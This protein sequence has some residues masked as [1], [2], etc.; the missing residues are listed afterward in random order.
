MVV[1]ILIQST[2]DVAAKRTAQ[3]SIFVAA[4]SL[5]GPLLPSLEPHNHK[6]EESAFKPVKAA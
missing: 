2:G 1:K 4:S 6:F 3:Q 5:L